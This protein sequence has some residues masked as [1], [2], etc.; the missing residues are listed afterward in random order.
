MSMNMTYVYKTK[1]DDFF[2]CLAAHGTLPAQ[3]ETRP[4]TLL[5]Y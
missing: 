1:D 5:S 3:L 2:N 4:E